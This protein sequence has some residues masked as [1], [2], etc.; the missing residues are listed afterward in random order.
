MQL[1]VA[2]QTILKTDMELPIML[3][4]TSKVKPPSATT[5]T[6]MLDNPHPMPLLDLGDKERCFNEPNVIPKIN[7]IEN[8]EVTPLG[9][10]TIIFHVSPPLEC[11]I[12]IQSSKEKLEI[13][14]FVSTLALGSRPRQ[15]LAKV[16]AIMLSGV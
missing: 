16:W 3:G 10:N 12:H 4:A 9:T 2:P 13:P 5:Y 1:I 7:I 8:N 6:I 11:M 14:I 15:G